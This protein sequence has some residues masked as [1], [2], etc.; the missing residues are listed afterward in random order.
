MIE[1]VS[2]YSTETARLT[3]NQARETWF[4]SVLKQ[5]YVPKVADSG[6]NRTRKRKI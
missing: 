5:Y 6:Q 4:W 1:E 3:P 2:T